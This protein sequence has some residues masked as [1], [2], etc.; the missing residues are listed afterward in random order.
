MMKR[1]VEGYE[2]SD[3][4]WI[5]RIKSEAP[6]VIAILHPDWRGIRSSTLRLYPHH[7]FVGDNITDEDVKYIAS[8]L[9][10]TGIKRFLFSGLANSHILLLKELHRVSPESKKYVLWH[11]NFLQSGEDYV[12]N[13][14]KTILDF[15]KQSVI[16]KIGFVKKGMDEVMRRQ[17]YRSGFVMN[18]VPVTVDAPSVPLAGGPHLGI[19]YIEENWRKQ[20]FAMMA[21]SSLIE[22]ALLHMPNISERSKDFIA[23]MGLNVEYTGRVIPQEEMPG[24]LNKM[25]LNL[26]VTLSECAPMLPLESLSAGAPCLVGPSSH[27]FTDDEYLSGRLIVPYP[28]SAS[29]IG[30]Y[31]NKALQDREYIVKR[32]IQYARGYNQKA[33]QSALDFLEL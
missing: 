4:E 1:K 14:F 13:S 25:H 21:A 31:I 30:R 22:G 33:K 18:F 11:A 15:Y 6:P 8:V 12:W 17:G 28:D 7:Y 23:T 5:Q 24:I 26:Y 2:P 10:A 32:Y 3:T 27:L 20:P 9:L 16:Y 29:V 19:W